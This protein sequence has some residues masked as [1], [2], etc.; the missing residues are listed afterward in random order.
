MRTRMRD[1]ASGR[2]VSPMAAD[3]WGV[4][5]G[6]FDAAGTWFDADP[7]VRVS[8]REAMGAPPDGSGTPPD[9]GIIISLSR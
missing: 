9:H 3:E 7:A 5:D 6:F 1:P 4:A 2:S 8:I